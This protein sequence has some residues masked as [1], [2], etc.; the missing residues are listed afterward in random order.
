MSLAKQN[1]SASYIAGE[2]SAQCCYFE[3]LRKVQKVRSLDVADLRDLRPKVRPGEP[4]PLEPWQYAELIEHAEKLEEQ[5]LLTLLFHTGLRIG[6]VLS[7]QRESIFEREIQTGEGPKRVRWL[8]VIGKGGKERAVPLN[9]E[10]ERV[11]DRYTAYIDMKYPKGCDR[12]FPRKSYTTA[13][14][15]LKK[16]SVSCSVPMNPHQLRHSFATELLKAGENIV[17]IGQIMGHESLDTTK[18]YTK[19][20][21]A[22]M[23]S[24]VKRLDPPTPAE[25]PAPAEESDRKG[26]LS[27]KI[28]APETGKGEEQGSGLSRARKT[29]EVKPSADG[30]I[31]HQHRSVTPDSLRPGAKCIWKGH[32]L[33]FIERIPHHANKPAM[34]VFRADDFVGLNGEGDEGLLSFP[35]RQLKELQWV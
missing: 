8:R 28:P 14:R 6:E 22:S 24:A 20:V 3:F 4:R 19:L 12:L 17:T 7:L 35:D 15:Q 5:T 18:K 13:W 31:S 30:Q 21:D 29:A 10:A 1:R 27:A 11:L 25:V 23:V 9:A 2:L 32:L 26:A 34:N 16:I 33:H